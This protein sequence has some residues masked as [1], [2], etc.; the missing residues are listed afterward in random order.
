M[1]VNGF[2]QTGIDLG[3]MDWT[4]LGANLGMNWNKQLLQQHGDGFTAVVTKVVA[5]CK[6]E[7]SNQKEMRDCIVRKYLTWQK[8]LQTEEGINCI[9]DNI[10]NIEWLDRIVACGASS[11]TFN[12]FLGA[13]LVTVLLVRSEKVR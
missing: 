2:S 12:V 3:S 13:I 8:V 7:G 10:N 6:K 5:Q 11:V 9:L 4:G 1:Q